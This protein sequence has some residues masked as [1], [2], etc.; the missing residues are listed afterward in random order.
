MRFEDSED[1]FDHR[2]APRVGGLAGRRSQVGPHAAVDRDIG[3]G[4]A[5]RS[6]IQG[7]G[8]VRVRYISVSVALLHLL[9]DID[10]EGAA[11]GKHGAGRRTATL[12][13]LIHHWRQRRVVGDALHHPLGY[14]QGASDTAISPV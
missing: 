13:N 3:P 14:D 4:A 7:L 1:R 2:F 6:Q 11:I 9:E 5:D 10:R 8:H 12:F